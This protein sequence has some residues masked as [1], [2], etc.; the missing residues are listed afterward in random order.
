MLATISGSVTESL[1]G[2]VVIE[3]NGLGYQVRISS[4]DLA[5]L[6]IGKKTR[7][8][9]YEHIRE[10]SHELY[11]FSS[12]ESKLL[13]EQLV[14]VSGVGPKVAIAILS[15]IPAEQ[16]QAAIASGDTGLL[17][18]VS[19]VGKKM[20]AR[21]VIDLKTKLEGGINE[22]LSDQQEP[23]LAAL[24]QLGFSNKQAREALQKVPVSTKD[25]EGRLRA[26][27]KELGK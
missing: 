3:V 7:L 19:G 5:E 23:T 8:Y 1:P 11:G 12:L 2:S 6:T 22:L 14:G 25:E 13:F 15:E 27:L 26:A 18:S 24:L 4:T 9:V 21:I 17:Q 10:D 20:A 16:L